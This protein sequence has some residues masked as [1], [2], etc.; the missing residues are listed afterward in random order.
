MHGVF[1]FFSLKGA[2]E[3]KRAIRIRRLTES[4]FTTVPKIEEKKEKVMYTFLKDYLC[5]CVLE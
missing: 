5:Q 3:G 4:V 1:F 2:E